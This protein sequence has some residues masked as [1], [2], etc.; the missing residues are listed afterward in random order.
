MATDPDIDMADLA[1]LDVL[2]SSSSSAAAAPAP[3]TRFSL[4]G[5][6]K[7][8]PKPK[9]KPKPEPERV[10]EPESKPQDEPRGT[11]AAPPEDGVDAMETDG[12]AASVGTDGMNHDE[13]FLVREIDVYFTPKPF[14]DDTMLYI[15]QYPLRPCWRPYELN[16]ICK[17]VRVKPRCS[18]VEVDLDIDTDSGNYDSDVSSSS[19]LTK[20]TLSSSEAADVSDYAVGV[21]SGNLVH[22]NHIDAVMQLRPSMSH[23]N[24][25]QSHTKQPVQQRETNGTPTVT[26]IKSN[27]L[28][29]GSKDCIEESEPWISLA[30]EPAGSDAASK[31]LDEMVSNEGSP[32]GFNMSTSDYWMSLCPG[33]P[34]GRKN[35]N[36]CQAI[37]EMLVLPLE[38]RLKKWF[39]EVSQVSRFDALM[40]LAPTYSEEDILKILPMYAD[41]E[42]VPMKYIDR[43]IRD[44][45]T[46]H[47][48]LNPLCKKREKLEDYKF[49]AEADSSFIKR[50]SHIVNEQEI[51][52]SVRGTTMSDLQE[53]CSTTE[54]RKTKNSTRSNIIA[55][56]R[57]QIIGKAKDVQ[58]SENPVKIVLD[59]VFTTNKVRSFAAVVRDLRHLAAK[60]ASDR[61]DGA[62]FQ[63]LSNAAKTCV[64]LSPK[65]LDA[66]IRLVAVLV[67]D[68]YIQKTEDKATLRNVLIKLFR[69]RD[70]NGTVNKQEILDY[71]G[72]VLKKEISEKEYHQAVSEICISTE[73]GQLVLKNGD[74]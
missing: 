39:T 74:T 21:L 5:K 41:L 34:T 70:P 16:E 73:E 20:Q 31:Y 48:I 22:L 51:A 57:D 54:Q 12:V 2:A 6:S 40:H 29:D 50:Y 1:S 44:D 30:Y 63:T 8:K 38:D 47:M 32:I 42:S 25:V 56:G 69:D 11:E 72:K 59:I 65:E 62:R 13:D 64:S 36:K 37:R 66:S 27:G 18:K 28:S 58:G 15:M 17:E 55:K 46:R 33:A 49:I 52:W 7:G 24:S 43:L 68:V 14:D 19:K 26:S 10:P 71:A 3:S 60:Y 35:I 67:H 53:T 4:K 23:L 61:K 45:R 9:P